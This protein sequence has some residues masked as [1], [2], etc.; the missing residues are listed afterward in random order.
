[1]T[2]PLRDR[3]TIL[4]RL[5]ADA[6]QGQLQFQASAGVA[7]RVRTALDDPALP[8]PAA[9]RLIQAEPVLAARVVAMA[10]S[11]AFNRSGKTIDD[12][13]SAVLRLGFR[14]LRSLA[15][16]FLVRQIG[17]E[18]GDGDAR[19]HAMV[20]QLW[21]HTA[22]VAAL[23]RI[24]AARVTRV[25]PELALFAA[26]VHEIGG[27]YLL[28]RA[29]EYP[30]LLDSDDAEWNEEDVMALEIALGRQVLQAL[31]VPRTATE[32]VEAC[33]E[34]YLA[35][36]PHT[37][38]DTVLLADELAPVPSPLREAGLRRAQGDENGRSM[39]TI[40]MLV[41][42]ETLSAI[43]AESREELASVTTAL[44]F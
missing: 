8:L 26:I 42:Q 37:L 16:A 31:G 5:I 2:A 23:S 18:Q 10:N 25:D 13:R 30:A 32:G 35:I 9:A 20:H 21:E 36:P 19:R 7:L 39:A 44:Q 28:S 4:Q 29:E 24:L 22:H 27:F 34:G 43:L 38:G 11:V 1:M 6:A 14:T 33:W 17:A 3:R 15:T 41:D 12:V 40:E